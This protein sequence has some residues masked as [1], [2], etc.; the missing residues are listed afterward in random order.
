MVQSRVRAVG[1]TRRWRGALA[2]LVVVPLLGLAACS[3][4]GPTSTLMRPADPVVLTGVD[5]P[6]LVGT[7][8]GDIVAFK[9]T[10]A[11]HWVQVPVQVDERKVVNFGTAYHGAANNV[12]V[13]AYADPNTYAGADTDPLLDANDEIAFM[14]R[15]SGGRPPAYSVPAGVVATSGIQVL[16]SDPIAV[17]TG[18]SALLRT[19]TVYLFKR[20]GALSPGAGKSYVSY[21]FQLT[22]GDYKTTYKFQD[23]PNPESS[24]ITT[25]Y[26]QHH[27][28]DRWMSDSIKVTAPGASGVDILDR[29][30][31]LFAPGNCGRS[32]DTFDDA[33]GAFIVNKSGPVRA[34]RSYI[35]ANS[36]P[37]TQREHIFYDQREDVRTYLRVHAIPG[38]MDFFD[39]SPAASGMKYTSDKNPAGVTIDGVPDTV[40]AGVPAWEKVD[41]PQGSLTSVE[42]YTTSFA[43]PTATN[44]YLDDSTPGTGAETQCTGDATAYGSSGTRLTSNLP[45][46]DP[47]TS[48][49]DT[50][51]GYRTLFFESP[52][53][54]TADAKLSNDRVKA[55]L[56]TTFSPWAAP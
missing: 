4:A 15:D 34:I 31:N 38:I 14:A 49:T 18:S 46:T 51:V 48:C 35:G 55:P 52:G 5:V 16:V 37:N 39:Y 32:E 43:A 44:Y 54:T 29:H 17:Q 23:G 13:V 9:Y 19:G 27:F 50:L 26:Y 20:S 21:Q 11:D 1:I 3:V 22:S 36:G 47:A 33:E 45:C 28:G 7:P 12:N 53:R 30:K 24:T 42:S 10:T 40:T 56:T 8:P 6:A 25:P 2:L 41:G